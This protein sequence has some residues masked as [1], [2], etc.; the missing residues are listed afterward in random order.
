[1]RIL[2]LLACMLLSTAAAPETIIDKRYA[3]GLE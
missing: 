3:V 1:M 2:F